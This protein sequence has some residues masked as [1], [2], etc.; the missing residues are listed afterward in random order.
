VPSS[1][2][3][4]NDRLPA[5]PWGRTWLAAVGLAVVVLAAYEGYFRHAG[6]APSVT[7]DGGLWALARSRVPPHDPTAVVLVGASR[8]Q[9]GLDLESF[10]AAFGGRTPVQLAIDGSSCV[11]AL[12]DLSRDPSFCGLVIVDVTPMWF[13]EDGADLEA[14]V[15]AEYVQQYRRQTAAAA[16][17]RGLRAAA[18]GALV[19]RLPDVAPTLRSLKRWCRA[20][21]LPRPGYLRMRPDRS[22]QA[23]YTR[24]DLPQHIASR[25]ERE[26]RMRPAGPDTLARAADSIREMI[27]RLRSRGGD[28]VLLTMP[29][30][31]EVREIELGHFP[32]HE[33]WDALLAQTGAVGIHFADYPDLS[34]FACPEGSHLD[35]NDAPEFSRALATILREQLDSHLSACTPA[36]DGTRTAGAESYAQTGDMQA[37]ALPDDGARA[38][39]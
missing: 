17:E 35:Q 18:Q 36:D 28:V 4:S 13:F 26:R 19:L 24:C 38:R 11:P 27:A 3:S 31:G 12:D 14:G 33:F 20:G 23:D 21:A 25:I 6:F 15:Q 29:V 1:T 8:I 22:K 16:I 9:L 37:A 5:G 10:A 2:S 34:R 30:S 32:R 39:P 7:D